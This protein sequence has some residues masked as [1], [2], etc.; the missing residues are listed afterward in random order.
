MTKWAKD[1]EHGP[2]NAQS[3]LRLFGQSENSVRVKLYRD[4]H[5]WCPYCQ[6]VWM[7]LEEKRIPYAIHKVT[8][9]CYGKKEPWYLK[10]VPRGML[11]ALDL[12]GRVITESDDILTALEHAFGPLGEPM[13]N[14]TPFRR[15]ERQLFSAWCQW[16]CR[17]ARSAREEE[18]NKRAFEEVLAEVDKTL[19]KTHGPYFLDDFSM[20]DV[21]F[22]PYV[23]RMLASL[24]YYKGFNMKEASPAIARWFAALETRETYRGTQSDA[25]THCHDLPPQMGGCYE[26]GEADQQVTKRSVDEGPW[27]ALPD[28]SYAQPQDAV[29]EALAQT[30]KHK[31]NII[32]ANCVKDKAKVEQALL[33]ALTTLVQPQDACPVTDADMAIALIYIRDRVNVP[34]DMSI[35]AARRMRTA[36][37]Q[38]AAAAGPVKAPPIPFED[39]Y[40]QQ[41]TQFISRIARV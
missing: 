16:L 36:L 29:E 17:P 4:N 38:S 2:T 8:M 14:I 3:R 13:A 11:P 24:Y 41:P 30:L 5:A 35:W 19:G 26:N 25:H 7:F 31:D 9:F 37:A 23:E 22:I 21:I 40:D 10:I 20:A 39:R 34:R 28:C 12:D 27:D 33:C 6:K 32:A 18:Y 15:L 1:Y